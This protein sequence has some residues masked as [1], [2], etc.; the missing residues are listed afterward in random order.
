ML[1]VV[2]VCKL[3]RGRRIVRAIGLVEY[4]ESVGRNRENGEAQEAA[5]TD[6]FVNGPSTYA[7]MCTVG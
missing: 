6:D 3:V 5:S 2:G 1:R 4:A 7:G